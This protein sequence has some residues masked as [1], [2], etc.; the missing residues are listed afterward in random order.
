VIQAYYIFDPRAHRWV[1]SVEGTIHW[2][3][4]KSSAT[5]IAQ[6]VVDEL[7]DTTAFKHCLCE[8][9]CDIDPTY[10]KRLKEEPRWPMART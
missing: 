1:Q 3:D 5:P 2:V 9:A 4:M 7:L 8:Y 10:S 6:D